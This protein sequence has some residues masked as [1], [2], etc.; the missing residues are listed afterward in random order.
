MEQLLQILTE[1]CPGIDF[2]TETDLIDAGFLD[3]MDVIS[4][5]AE[6]VDHFSIELNVEDLIPEHF[7]SA[8]AMMALIE[9]KQG[10]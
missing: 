9:R 10:L 6:L 7:N 8:T 3:S 4:I 2:E 1:T 5:V